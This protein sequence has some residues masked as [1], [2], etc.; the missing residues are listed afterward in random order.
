MSNPSNRITTDDPDLQELWENLLKF[1][2]D[3]PAADFS[4]SDRL[5]RENGWSPGYARQVVL[6]YKK[7]LFL[8]VAAGHPVCPS[9]QIDQVW[10]LHLVYTRSYWEELCGQVLKRPIHHGPT[11]GG[12]SEVNKHIEMYQQTLRT[13]EKFFGMEAPLAYWPVTSVRFGYDIH[14]RLG[15]YR[16]NWII[17]KLRP[18]KSGRRRVSWSWALFPVLFLAI[19]PWNLKGPDFIK[20]YLIAAAI[21]VVV[22][23]MIRAIAVIRDS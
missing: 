17:P 22:C 7:F 14:V 6:E 10:H 4:F 23:F 16:R 18:C 2:L 21:T 19:Y 12:S 9:E 5:A 20:F 8:C 15:N 13:Y 3:D 1:E 11:K